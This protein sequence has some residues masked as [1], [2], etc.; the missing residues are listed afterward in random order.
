[1][2]GQEGGRTR[3]PTIREGELKAHPIGR[4][5]SAPYRIRKTSVEKG[6]GKTVTVEGPNTARLVG[7]VGGEISPRETGTWGNIGA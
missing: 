5:H 7:K 1:M 3:G 2:L 4:V 6:K